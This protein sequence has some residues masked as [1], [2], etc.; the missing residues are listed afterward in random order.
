VTELSSSFSTPSASDR[1]VSRSPVSMCRRDRQGD[2]PADG[3]EQRGKMRA[4]AS[5]G[6]SDS[7]ITRGTRSIT[8]LPRS[9]QILQMACDPYTSFSSNRLEAGGPPGEPMRARPIPLPRGLGGRG[10]G[11]RTGRGGAERGQGAWRMAVMLPNPDLEAVLPERSG[12]GLPPGQRGFIEAAAGRDAR[13][14]P[15]RGAA[16]LAR[17]HLSA[18][19]AP[20]SRPPPRCSPRLKRSYRHVGPT[21]LLVAQAAKEVSDVELAERLGPHRDP[22]ASVRHR[23]GSGGAR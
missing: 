21:S 8:G 7:R 19:T 3:E 17:R 1:A 23:N 22:T 15:D 18:V 2:H 12:S 14:P 5:P 16:A 4:T 10:G 13:H 11:D 20:R 9:R 6:V